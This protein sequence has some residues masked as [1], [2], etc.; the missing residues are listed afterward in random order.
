MRKTIV[1][2]YATQYT[3]TSIFPPVDLE[4]APE[5]EESP[6]QGFTLTLVQLQR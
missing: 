1:R 2:K 4:T 6:W 5:G 3:E